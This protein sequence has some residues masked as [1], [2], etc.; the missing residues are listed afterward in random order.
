MITLT[1]I[2]N[3]TSRAVLKVIQDPLPG[4]SGK[5]WRM[6]IQLVLDPFFPAWGLVSRSEAKS[7][8][9]R[10]LELELSWSYMKILLT[11]K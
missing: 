7:E 11:V 5:S 3:E 8:E 6:R 2:L 9:K 1:T 4:F 10:G